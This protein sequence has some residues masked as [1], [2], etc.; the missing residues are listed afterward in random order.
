MLTW[1]RKLLKPLEKKLLSL[2]YQASL[3]LM[4]KQE[5][6]IPATIETLI[7]FINNEYFIKAIGT[8][9]SHLNISTP[10]YS[11]SELINL[12]RKI[13]SLV[14]TPNTR[15]DKLILSRPLMVSNLDKFFCDERGYI[16]NEEESIKQLKEE[17][18]KY[19]KFIRDFN[20]SETN[21]YAVTNIRILT[22]TTANIIQCLKALIELS[23]V[24]P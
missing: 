16:I 3:K 13:N 19:A 15:V 22:S 17:V 11:I 4:E 18:L 1:L 12:I 14:N 2:S 20:E 8:R 21:F 23:L 6:D 5:T 7:G 24:L 9:T 10:Y